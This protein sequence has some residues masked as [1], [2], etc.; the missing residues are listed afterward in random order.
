[1]ND[2][3][4]RVFP[5]SN[6]VQLNLITRVPCKSVSVPAKSG[7]EYLRSNVTVYPE[8]TDGLR[9]AVEATTTGRLSKLLLLLEDKC[10]NYAGSWAWLCRRVVFDTPIMF[11]PLCGRMSVHGRA[12][13]SKGRLTVRISQGHMTFRESLLCSVFRKSDGMKEPFLFH[14][15]FQLFEHCLCILKIFC[16]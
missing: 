4:V 1:M 13:T 12:L 11:E 3:L 15:L 8:K 6:N 10:G 16:S 2:L 7:T 9:E 14:A 5:S